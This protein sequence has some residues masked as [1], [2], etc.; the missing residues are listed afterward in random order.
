LQDEDELCAGEVRIDRDGQRGLDLIV[1]FRKHQCVWFQEG[2]VGDD[3]D[4]ARAFRNE[5]A[6]VRREC[7][8]GRPIKI[9]RHL[10]DAKPH[11]VARGVD[12]TALPVGGGAMSDAVIADTTTC[13]SGDLGLSPESG[14]TLLKVASCRVCAPFDIGGSFPVQAKPDAPAAPEH[15]GSAISFRVPST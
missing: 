13:K 9:L 6:T 1:V 7:G 4:T 3:T 14:L 10:V 5:Q 15:D 2:A 11:A 8:V 12:L